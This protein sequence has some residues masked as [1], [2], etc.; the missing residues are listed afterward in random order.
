ME[1]LRGLAAQL[2]LESDN[3]LHRPMRKSCRAVFPVFRC[4]RAEFN[5]EGFSNAIV[6]YRP[7]APRRFDR[8]RRR[9][10]GRFEGE[11]G[12]IVPAGDDRL[13]APAND[14]VLA[15]ER[16]AAWAS[17][18]VGHLKKAFPASGTCQNHT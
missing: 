15:S 1:G 2:G 16:R 12:Y 5:A 6:E 13:M 11:T 8:C 14:R 9:A 3:L 4:M 7:G 10:R 17:A 18:Q